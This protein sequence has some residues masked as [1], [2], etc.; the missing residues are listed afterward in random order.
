[1]N[2]KEPI[3][4]LIDACRPGS[5][6]LRLP[7]MEE[8]ADLVDR[9][10]AV[11]S[12]LGR[13]Q[14]FDQAIAAAMD[15][16][17]VPEGLE[18]RLLA[19]AADAGASGD[20]EPDTSE[21]REKVGQVEAAGHERAARRRW[22]WVAS[23]AAAAAVIGVVAGGIA[24]WLPRPSLERTRIADAADR[25]LDQLIVSEGIWGK[26]DE[27]R[28]LAAYP[29]SSFL[30]SKPSA[31]RRFEAEVLQGSDSL[32]LDRN[33]V[34]YDLRGNVGELRTMLFVV[35]TSVAVEASDIAP[36]TP[37]RVT[38]GWSI[39][40]WQEGDLVYVLAVEGD[41]DRYRT[42]VKPAPRLA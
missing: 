20:D 18:A 1:M 24:W 25:W 30:K 22:L 35:R 8:L 3:R 14:K 5:D 38:G 28:V 7:E 9:D 13:S 2:P 40:V 33:A 15:T 41:E 4:E 42:F 12:L 34:V 37:T 26:D 17:S 19:A 39:G 29:T 11:A 23:F 21:N 16:G 32:T 27:N 6:D 36:R 10:P 31:W